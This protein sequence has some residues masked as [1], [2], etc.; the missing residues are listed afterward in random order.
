MVKFIN[1]HFGTEM[2]VAENRVEEYKAAG[3]KLAASPVPIK[4]EPKEETKE[5]KEVKKISRKK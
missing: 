5:V 4:Q 3:H 2:W 1:N